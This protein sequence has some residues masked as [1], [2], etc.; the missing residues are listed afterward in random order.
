MQVRTHP[1]PAPATAPGH[2]LERRRPERFRRPGQK[3]PGIQSFVARSPGAPSRTSPSPFGGLPPS[4][5]HRRWQDRFGVMTLRSFSKSSRPN[6][7]SGTTSKPA[8][9]SRAT[10]S[11]K[12][13]DGRIGRGGA[14][15]RS[16]PAGRGTAGGKPS[17]VPPGAA[18]AAGLPPRGDDHPST[19][20]VAHR[21]QRSTRVLPDEQPGDVSIRTLPD[22][23]PG[24]VCLAGRSPDR[25][26]ALTPPFHR[27]HRGRRLCL[28]VAL[29][30]RFPSP[31]V[32]RRPALRSSDFPRPGGP[33]AAICPPPAAMLGQR[34]GARHRSS[35]SDM[36]KPGEV[37][38]SRIW[39]KR[40]RPAD[41]ASQMGSRSLGG[42]PRIRQR[43]G[44]P[45]EE[46]APSRSPPPAA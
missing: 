6:S 25:R 44:T 34:A 10:W 43:G 1:H 42:R 26:W 9:P 27:C 15:G 21:L 29:S 4:R 31:G 5:H 3:T 28:S 17:S 18:R 20:V 13:L 45:P 14:G 37:G 23:A 32:T 36:C 24:G 35:A 38:V 41:T 22:L 19:P 11:N 7:V 30:L 46:S 16:P 12:A 39:C 2:L 33:A 40:G 8:P